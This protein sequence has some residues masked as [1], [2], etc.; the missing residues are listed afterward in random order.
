M[1]NA[2]F[3]QYDSWVNDTPETLNAKLTALATQIGINPEAFSQCLSS[4]KH[5]TTVDNDAKDGQAVGANATP[6]FFINGQILV[7]A[8]PYSTF[9]TILDQEL[10]K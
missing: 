7:G 3:D 4:N 2:L 6:T 9:Q 5:T 1:H 8:L 10:S